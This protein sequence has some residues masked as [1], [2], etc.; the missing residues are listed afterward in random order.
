MSD[1]VCLFITLK[2][3]V[4]SSTVCA[5]FA[6]MALKNFGEIKESLEN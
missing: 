4:S 1:A 3:E 2:F 6:S 5:K